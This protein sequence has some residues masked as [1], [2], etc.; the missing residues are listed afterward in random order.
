MKP[1]VEFF[2]TRPGHGQRWGDWNHFSR[3]YPAC[4]WRVAKLGLRLWPFPEV[5]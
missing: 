2:H 4:R 5:L 1:G 3:L